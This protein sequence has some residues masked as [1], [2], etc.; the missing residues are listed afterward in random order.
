MVLDNLEFLIAGACIGNVIAWALIIA[1]Y[2]WL[3]RR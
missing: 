1:F 2:K 3:D